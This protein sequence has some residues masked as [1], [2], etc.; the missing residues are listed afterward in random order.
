MNTKEA[1]KKWGCA[2]STVRDYCKSGIIP[3]AEKV[4]GKWS[5]PDE[6]QML[7]PVTANR[8]VYLMR[9]I[10]DDVLPE[11]DKYWDAEKMT[12]ALVY[13]SDMRFIIDFE[14][15]SSLE[16][17][18]KKSRVSNIGNALIEA[19]QEKS[20]KNTFGIEGEAGIKE[21]VPT[22]TGRLSFKH[23]E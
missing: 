10:Q 11:T 4:G 12:E 1:A 3:L 13:L 16:E 6:M 5:I 19:V 17:A 18:A 8:A 7:P 15:H 14:G 9:C 21:G 23:E 20:G 22:A 2:E